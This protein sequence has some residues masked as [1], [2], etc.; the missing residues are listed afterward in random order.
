M[1][2]RVRGWHSQHR[3]IQ[4]YVTDYEY[5]EVE[6]LASRM[7]M[8]VSE[9]VKKAIMDLKGL[10]EEAYVKG[11]NDGFESGFKAGEEET[12]WD[13]SRGIF[14]IEDYGLTYPK[15]PY[16][17]K[18]MSSVIVK[19]G[20]NLGSWVLQKIREEGWHHKSCSQT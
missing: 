17:G 19:S 7:N 20:S 5:R 1:D 6:E 13:I 8:S 12:L 14:N 3:R 18:P 2:E 16:C 9:L 11:F 4:C 15:C 10:K